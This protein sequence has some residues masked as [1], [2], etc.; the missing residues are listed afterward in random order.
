MSS[1]FDCK[2]FIEKVCKEAECEF[3]SQEN[4]TICDSYFN[5]KK[6]GKTYHLDSRSK[7]S[8]DTT[9][10]ISL[11]VDNKNFCKYEWATW[12]A[13][14]SFEDLVDYIKNERDIQIAKDFENGIIR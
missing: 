11:G 3:I 2:P 5:F 4:Y 7:I 12:K 9:I 14:D 10:V 6:N 1:L 8:G 13:L